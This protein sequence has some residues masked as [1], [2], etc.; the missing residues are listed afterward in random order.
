MKKFILL[1]CAISIS[2]VIEAQPAKWFVTISTG[3][4]IAGPA[5]SLKKYM[6]DNGFDQTSRGWI[7]GPVD[8]PNSDLGPTFLG[9]FGK[10]INK[11]RSVYFLL[12]MPGNGEVSGYDGS[13]LN[14]IKYHIYQFGAG[15]QFFSSNSRSTVGMGPSIF[16]LKSGKNNHT[17]GND[18]LTEKHTAVKPGVSITGRTPLGKGKRLVG[19]ELFAELNIAP[20]ATYID[21]QSYNGKTSYNMNMIGGILGLALSASKR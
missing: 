15:Y 19:I 17:Q 9:M 20:K 5:S 7:F 11:N 2:V 13:N 6:N 16:I 18:D 14:N 3:L 10:Q 1:S 4:Q 21:P 8:Y 12:G